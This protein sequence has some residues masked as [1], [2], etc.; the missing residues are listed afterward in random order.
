L[1]CQAKTANIAEAE[2]SNQFSWGASTHCSW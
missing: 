2:Q 1:R